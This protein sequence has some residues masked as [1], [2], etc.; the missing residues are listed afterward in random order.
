MDMPAKNDYSTQNL[1]QRKRTIGIIAVVL[2]LLFT[3]L[4]IAQVINFI[5]WIVGDL[6]VAVIANVL[7]RRAGR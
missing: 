4:A 3:V 6:A 7:L 5:E 2:L 1:R